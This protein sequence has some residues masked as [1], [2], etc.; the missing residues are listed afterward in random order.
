LFSAMTFDLLGST[1]RWTTERYSRPLN[2]VLITEFFAAVSPVVLNDAKLVDVQP[3]ASS[4][5][6]AP[7]SE[8]SGRSASSSD[9]KR[10]QRSPRGGPRVLEALVGLALLV[11]L[12]A[13]ASRLA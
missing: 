7:S 8:A 2:Q 5:P 4:S 11:A 3:A 6:A 12:G 9:F 1:A 10:P 13:L